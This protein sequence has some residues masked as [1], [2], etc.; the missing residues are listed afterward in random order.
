MDAYPCLMLCSWNSYNSFIISTPMEYIQN[1][2][3]LLVFINDKSYN[4]LF[5]ERVNS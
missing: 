2:N 4:G 5:I 3:S 1:H